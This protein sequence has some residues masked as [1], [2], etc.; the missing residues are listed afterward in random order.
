MKAVKTLFGG[1]PKP[2]K[3]KYPALPPPA[4]MPTADDDAVKEAQRRAAAERQRASG[5]Y[6]TILTDSTDILGA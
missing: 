6:S 5:R 2:Q 4:V 1:A 3:V